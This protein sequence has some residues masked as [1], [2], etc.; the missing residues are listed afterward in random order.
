LTFAFTA[1]IQFSK[2][3][4]G[5]KSLALRRKKKCFSYSHAKENHLLSTC[6]KDFL[7]SARTI[8]PK[9]LIVVKR[10]FYFF[11]K[12]RYVYLSSHPARTK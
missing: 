8:I 7:S 3:L 6:L 1:S 11:K 10:I 5:L 4:S 12:S 2:N 9:A